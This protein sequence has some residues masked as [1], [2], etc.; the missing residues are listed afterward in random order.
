MD[1]EPDPGDEPTCVGGKPAFYLRGDNN[2]PIPWDDYDVV[3]PFELELDEDNATFT[4][5]TLAGGDGIRVDIESND[6]V[7]KWHAIFRT[8]T[9]GE[10]VATRRLRG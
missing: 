7:H 6:D 5:T 9:V 8:R 2:G 1:P 4:A 10:T 3:Y